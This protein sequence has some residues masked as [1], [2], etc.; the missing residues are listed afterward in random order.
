MTTLTTTE[1]PAAEAVAA[2]PERTEPAT[3]GRI[4]LR[5][6]LFALLARDARVMRRQLFDV[7]LRALM[8]PVAFIF[9]FTYVLPKIGMAGGGGNTSLS[10]VLVPGL[11]AITLAV[12]GIT[13]VMMPL[14]LDLAI[15]REI[16]DRALAPAP[17]WL[18]GVQK[19]LSAAFQALF[20]GLVVFPVTLYLH[21]SGESPRVHVYSWPLF[22]AVLVLSCL[23][24]GCVGLLVGTVF[25]AHK[26]QQLFAV[27]VTPLTMLG[28]VYYPWSQL[29]AI[30]W[31]KV[32]TLAN[33]V[34]YMSEGLRAALTPEVGHM[35]VAAILG[36]LGG[37]V[38]VVGGLA[39]RL[40]GRRVV[41]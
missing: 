33:P 28:C 32:A 31:L 34:V 18:I 20:A 21:A 30:P 29:D 17:I 9:V 25:P 27:I 38:I 3:L 26:A 6:T 7:I 8:Q 14:L 10:T 5:H 13:A 16:E 24:A 4:P 12:Q 41:G 1:T 11:V 37:G 2:A 36:V 15:T 40:F 23:L 35:P 19:I 39:L 22:V